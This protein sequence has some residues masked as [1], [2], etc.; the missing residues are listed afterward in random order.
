MRVL[1]TGGAGYIGTTLVPLLLA[2][3]YQITVLDTLDFGIGPL[4]PFFREPTFSFV[5]ASVLDRYTLERAAADCDAIVHLAAVSGQHACERDPERAQAVNE[6]G[7]EAV[8]SITGRNRPLLFA[9][10][11]SCYGAVRKAICTE[12]TPL[13]PLSLYGRTKAA[14][15]AIVR[16]QCSAV[17]YRFATGYGISPRMRPELLINYFVLAALKEPKLTVFEPFARRTFIHVE[18]IARAILFALENVEP[19]AGSTYNVGD[20][21]QNLTKQQVVELIRRRLPSIRV[22]CDPQEQDLDRRDYA[23]SYERIKS[24]GFK[25]RIS[26]EAGIDELI[27]ALRWWRQIEGIPA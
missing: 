4:F 14:G 13:H 1:V 10:S 9:S 25:T 22:D 7:T 23:V 11:G 15:E 26:V 12:Q 6:R 18:D 2:K 21:S 5:Q 27:R 20:E 17:I 16:G 8:A 19:M 24:L 3:E